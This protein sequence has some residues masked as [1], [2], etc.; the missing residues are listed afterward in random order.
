MPPENPNDEISLDAV[1]A[2]NQKLDEIALSSDNQVQGII[3][4]NAQLDELNR[5]VEMIVEQIGGLKLD[6]KIAIIDA[7]IKSI[8]L[9]DYTPEIKQV[10]AL[11][12]ELNNKPTPEIKPE[13]EFKIEVNGQE[14][15]SAYVTETDE[16]TNS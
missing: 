9:T 6:E 14:I 3:E 1:I 16:E 2:Q 10:I 11:L 13:I 15:E 8:Q 12:T 7:T 4:T 5:G